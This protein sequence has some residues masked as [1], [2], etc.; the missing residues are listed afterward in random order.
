[1]KKALKTTALVAIASYLIWSFY[2]TTE[3][4]AQAKAQ[5]QL[6][7]RLAA[8]D[9]LSQIE[10]EKVATC[11]IKS[12]EDGGYVDQSNAFIATLFDVIQRNFEDGE[13]V[14]TQHYFPTNNT[15][16]AE[17]FSADALACTSNHG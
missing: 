17:G 4:V 13:N 15:A 7:F 10:R 16:F 12:Y 5:V 9:S 8:P 11:I 2:Q 1:M 6:T 14:A 3:Y